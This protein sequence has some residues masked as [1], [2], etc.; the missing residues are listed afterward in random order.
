[1]EY[2]VEVYEKENGEIPFTDFWD[3]LSGKLRAKVLRDIEL[4]AQFGNEL[5]EPYTKSLEDGIFELSSIVGKNNS[6]TLFFFY[7]DRK[8]VIT[9]GFLKKQN[10]TP[11]REIDTAVRYR[12]DW[13]RRKYDEIQ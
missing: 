13:I 10:K 3:D 4:P 12:A 2:E 5:R 1:M 9:H 8:I 7:I 6:R 11:H